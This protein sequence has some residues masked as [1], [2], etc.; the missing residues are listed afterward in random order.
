MD[1]DVTRPDKMFSSSRRS[2]RKTRTGCNNCKRRK[3][4]VS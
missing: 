1:S 3:I 4:K 2:H